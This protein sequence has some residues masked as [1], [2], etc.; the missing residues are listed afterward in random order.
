MGFNDVSLNGGGVAGGTVHTPHIDSIAREGVHFT[1]GYAGNGTCA[2]SRAMLMTGR[3]STRFGFEFTPAG[4]A[5]MRLIHHYSQN[6]ESERHSV[7]Y[8]DREEH[9]PDMSK[10]GVPGSEITL[11]ELLQERGYRTLMLGKWH[12]GEEPDMQPHNRGFDEWLGFLRGASLYARE[13]DPNVVNAKL[14]SNAIDKFL[15]ANIPYAVQFNDSQRFEARGYLTE[16]LTD[17]AIKAIRANRHR[18]FFLY[19][20]HFAPHNPLQATREDY[21][22][23]SHIEDHAERVYAAMIRALDRE[24]GRITATLE[25]LGLDEN[26]M[27]IFTS[28]NGGAHYVGLPDINQPYRGWKSTFFEGGVKT[29]FY[30]RWPAA[31][32]EPV[33][34]DQPVIHADLFTTIARAAGARVPDDRTMDGVDLLPYVDGSKAG[35]P[36]E[37]LFWHQGHYSVAIADGWKLQTTETPKKT[38]LSHLD[39]DPAEQVN[40][41]DRHPERVEALQ[42]QLE[43]HIAEQR[44]AIW[45]AL[46]EVPV[47]IDKTLYDPESPDDEYVYW[48]N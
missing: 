15:W 45:P 36:H 6:P 28:D 41:A 34:Y 38:W 39:Q 46:L 1:N 7:Y 3:Y 4:P 14:P 13:D 37:A 23:L 16:Y 20:A 35:R 43:Q 33:R 47:P 22:A 40:L 25:E 19:L 21:E 18:P 9:M 26:T 27:V 5:F 12:L 31:V 2:P 48:S 42:A 8:H 11:P 29:P 24:V 17:E 30:L 32:P 44:K 10:L